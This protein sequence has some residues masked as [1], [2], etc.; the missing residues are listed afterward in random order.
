MSLVDDLR[1][2]EERLSSGDLDHYRRVCRPD[3]LFV[4][5][6]M[7]ASLDDAIAGLEQ[8][9][10]W[11]RFDLSAVTLRELGDAG[12]AIAY[13][14]RGERGDVVYE[15]DMVSTYARTPDGWRLVVHQQ[16]PV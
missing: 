9:P 12:A 6:G 4:M 8:S 3:A 5:P 13:R 11:D 10:P 1:T 15:A 14:F 7:V 2:S 16:T